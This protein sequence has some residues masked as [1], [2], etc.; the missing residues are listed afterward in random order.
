MRQRVEEIKSPQVPWR[1]TMR[2]VVQPVIIHQDFSWARPNR[3]WAPQG[4]FMPELRSERMPAGVVYWDTS[5]SRD[6]ADARAEAGAEVISII[7]E[8]RPEKLYVIY[9]DTEVT[10]VEIFE[11][12]DVITFNPVGGG[13]TAFEPIFSWIEENQIEPAFFIGITDAIG[14]FPAQA[15]EYPTIWCVSGRGAVPFGERIQLK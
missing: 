4:I 1:E 7:D 2:K 13:G 14:S 10:K 12:D 5:G 8:C 6:Y 15:P 11:P 9:G 3:R